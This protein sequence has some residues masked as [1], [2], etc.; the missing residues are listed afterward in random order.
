MC[1]VLVAGFVSVNRPIF[2]WACVGGLDTGTSGVPW[3]SWM[4]SSAKLRSHGASQPVRVLGEEG[5]H[6]HAGVFVDE[7]TL[8]EQRHEACQRL[9]GARLGCLRRSVREVL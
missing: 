1:A 8:Q 9:G 7:S 2:E 4:P 6:L 3:L 5:L